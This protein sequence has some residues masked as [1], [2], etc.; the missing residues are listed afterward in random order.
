MASLSMSCLP[1]VCPGHFLTVVVCLVAWLWSGE[2][3]DKPACH[4]SPLYPLMHIYQQSIHSVIRILYEWITGLVQQVLWKLLRSPTLTRLVD[5]CPTVSNT[6]PRWFNFPWQ[7]WLIRLA[8]LPLANSILWVI[9][10]NLGC[11]ICIRLRLQRRA[12]IH[13]GQPFPVDFFSWSYMKL[14]L[15]MS[16]QKIFRNLE[17]QWNL[18]KSLQIY[19]IW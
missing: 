4:D 8:L 16:H 15:K 10:A 12:L 19:R 18:M 5:F 3:D 13:P 14:L 6:F 7:V 2:K 1:G 9:M 17:C 11:S